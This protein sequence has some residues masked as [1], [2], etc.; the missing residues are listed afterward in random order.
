MISRLLDFR[1][2][3]LAALTL[4]LV[5]S[6]GLADEYVRPAE[7]RLRAD[8]TYLADDLREGRGP[9]TTGIDAAADYIATVFKE[10]GLKPAKGAEGYFQPFEVR[11]QARVVP[12]TNLAVALP[13]GGSIAGALDETFNPLQV[14]SAG[15]VEDRPVVFAGYGITADDE[16]LGLDYNDYADVDAKDKVVLILRREPNFF[17]EN[18]DVKVTTPTIY[19]QFTSKVTNAA[20]HG[21]KAVLMVNDA[22]SARKSDDLIDFRGTPGGGTI[23]FLMIKRS[24]ADKILAA[25]DQ[26]SLDELE[27]QI[28]EAK[29]PRSVVLQGV[30]VNAEVTVNR[31]DLAVKNVIGVLEGAGPLAD[32]T[33]VVGAHYD[34]LGHGGLGSLAFGSREIHNG[35]DDNASGTAMVLELARRLA[36]REDPLPRRIVFMLFSAEERG[37]LGSQHYVEHPLYPIEKTVAMLNF[38]MVGRLNDDREMT[39]YGGG[40][41][42]GFENL[43]EALADSQGLKA[44]LFQGTR[45]E[46]NQ[47]D[48]ASFYRKE[49]P[50]LFFFTGTHP[51][52]HRPS[53]D[54]DK[55]NFAGMVHIA[56]LGELILLDLARRPDRPAFVKMSS[57]A[58]H[59]TAGAVRG[60]HGIYFGSR[61]NYAFD[62][63]GVKLDGVNEGSP[64]DKAGL[65][66]GDIVVKFGGLDVKDVESYMAAM[67]T[68]KPGEEV[69]VVV[70]RGEKEV[71]LKAKLGE[72]PSRSSDE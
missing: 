8:V 45:G 64:A 60:G 55:I 69:E 56:D 19:A 24:L 15:Q 66:G 14:G 48:H 70:K 26:P 22:E 31:D 25:A 53:D 4:C 43:V 51:D 29:K 57:P 7:S 46:F 54:S 65:R 40:S 63:E 42:E 9:G 13:D 71:T 59:A 23:P 33:I 28:H 21:A 16:K 32:E 30:K 50:V 17:G 61:P 58:P 38:D 3:W 35:A 10:G 18:P 1:R 27:K 37:L 12:P 36:R 67:S 44:K 49:I 5:A 72:R 52:Y 41:S 20:L 68:R 39:V 62:G 34:H 2:F 11:G 47:S 6:R